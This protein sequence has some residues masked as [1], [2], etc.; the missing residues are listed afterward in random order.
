MTSKKKRERHKRSRF[1]FVE[2]E[3]IE[4]SSKRG[5]NKFS[6][7]LVATWFSETDRHA[8]TNLK[9]SL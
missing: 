4:P 9:L 3:G 2:L 1:F 8:T 5:T 7:R 6:T